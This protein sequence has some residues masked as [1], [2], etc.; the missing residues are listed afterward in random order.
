MRYCANTAESVALIAVAVLLA[1]ALHPRVLGGALKL[2]GEPPGAVRRM[3]IPESRVRF[4]LFGLVLLTLLALLWSL[5]GLYT[6]PGQELLWSFTRPAG[7]AVAALFFGAT[8]GGLALLVSLAQHTLE[9]RLGSGYAS[10]LLGASALGAS[11]SVALM[12]SLHV[13]SLIAGAIVGAA[14]ISLYRAVDGL[15]WYAATAGSIV[16]ALLAAARDYL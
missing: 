6:G 13:L 12:D 5:A 14:V 7:A 3:G 2:V 16:G 11:L 15:P 10:L 8:F 1:L 9:R 4:Y